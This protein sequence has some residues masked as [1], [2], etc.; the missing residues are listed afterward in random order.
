M[1]SLYELRRAHF[2]G[3]H[4]KGGKHAKQ[5]GVAGKDVHFNVPIGTEVIEVKK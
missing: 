2:R 1:N 5:N 4:G 3:N